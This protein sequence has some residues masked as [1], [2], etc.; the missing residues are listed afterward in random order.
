MKY[1]K[2]GELL[3]EKGVLSS[4]G[5]GLCLAVQEAS[6][7][8]S[9]LGDVLKYYDLVSSEGVAHSLAEQAGWPY[10]APP[11]VIHEEAAAELGQDFLKERRVLPVCHEYRSAFVFANAYD[12]RTTD[13]LMLHYGQDVCFFIGNERAIQDAID[14]LDRKSGAAMNAGQARPADARDE[15]EALLDE[16]IVRHAT[17]IHFEA[18]DMALEVRLRIDGVLHFHRA[19]PLQVQPRIVNILFSKSEISAGDFLKLHDARFEHICQGRG[20]DVRLSHIPS[21]KGP[22]VVLRILD[23]AR[24]L[25]SLQALGYAPR[26]WERIT[27]ALKRPHGIILLTGPTGCGKTTSL[28]AMLNHVKGVGLKIVTIEDPV[29]IRLPFVT[30]VQVDLKKGHDFHHVARAFLRH[31]PDIILIG[32]IRDEKTAREAV[33]A[34]STGHRV[35]ATLHTNDAVSAIS[36]LKDLGLDYGDIAGT[37]TCVISQRLV[38]RLCPQCSCSKAVTRDEVDAEMRIFMAEASETVFY[39]RGCSFCCEGYRGRTVVGE[40]FVP[41]DH[42]RARIEQGAIREVFQMFQEKDALTIRK[43]A[44][45]LVSGGILSLEEALRVVG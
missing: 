23:K 26:H 39:P 38:R 4:G 24:S 8:A 22:S 18:S 13:H 19:F 12:T 31:D 9:R 40:V 6:S 35:F 34:A 42:M 29:E 21:V 15:V 11:F 45:R 27:G 10:L 14:G 7:G 3:V 16:A 41:D 1:T 33:R 17:D 20:Y 30:Q 25:A 32:E 36:R 28:Y 5:L 2:L 43:D 37:V 44:A